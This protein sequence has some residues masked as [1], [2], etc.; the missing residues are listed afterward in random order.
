M[1]A[2]E[3]VRLAGGLKRSAFTDEADLTRYDLERGTKVTSEHIPVLLAKA[4]AEE[5]DADIRLHDGDVLTIRQV[6]GWKDVGAT[7]AV[8][9]EVVHPGTY[10]IQEGERLSSIIARAG[11]FRSDAYPYGSIF[12]RAQVRE[13][14]EKNRE[15]LISEIQDQGAGLR[16]AP[17]TDP[18]QKA[19]KDA[20]LQQWQNTLVQL[21]NSPPGWQTGFAHF[22]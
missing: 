18:E 9:G 6:A 14:E 10:G 2:A 1:T 5:P 17:D 7:I 21:K 19:A 4:L 8:G 15:R 22:Q 12:E 16:Q 11:G 3:L 20:A 13:I